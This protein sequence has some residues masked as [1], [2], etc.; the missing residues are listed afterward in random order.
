MKRLV[1][2]CLVAGAVLL[3]TIAGLERARHQWDLTAESS[4]SLSAT[5]KSVVGSVGRKVQITAF[6]DRNLPGRAESAALLERYRRLNRRISYRLRDPSNA[7]GLAQR[8]GVDPVFGGVALQ[9]GS[10]VERAPTVTEQDVTAGLARIVRG[11]TATVCF[12]SGH[13]E[14]D[15]N[16]TTAAGYSRAAAVLTSNGYKV[17]TVDLLSATVIPPVCRVMVLAAPTAPLGTAASAAL[18]AFLVGDGRALVTADPESTV[19]LSPLTRPWGVGFERG[20]AVEGDADHH[21]PG[22]PLS[23]VVSSYSTANPIAHRLA[24]TVFPGAEAL[25]ADDA[26]A[27]GR[28]VSVIARTTKVAYLEKDP[29]AF[30]FDPGVDT[31]GPL[32]L[33]VATDQ[34]RTDQGHVHRTRIVVAAEG[35]WASNAFIDLA[36]NSRLLVQSLDWLTLDEDLVT[37]SANIPALRPLPLTDRRRSYALFMAVAIIPLFLLLVFASTWAVRRGR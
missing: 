9:S 29:A 24:P 5:T 28:T 34:S 31:G 22:D 11:T 32:D 33:V 25:V 4:L 27:R 8:L 3:A 16:A 13:G 37:V 1:L 17:Q 35:D 18:S 12:A 15:R 26:P 36:G 2:S 7:T 14:A 19:D 21:L 10:R 20:I 30:H 23:I 6:L